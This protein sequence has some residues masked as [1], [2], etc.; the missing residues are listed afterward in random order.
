MPC[1]GKFRAD[2]Y[3][4]TQSMRR[5]TVVVSAKSHDF[6]ADGNE[7]QFDYHRLMKIIVASGF[8]GIVAIEYEG[9]RLAPV[10]GVKAT[11]QLLKR[12]LAA[13]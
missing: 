3:A 2:V 12:A 11:Q 13:V 1:F 8:K 4:G 10:E 6:D 5:A 7:K 9:S